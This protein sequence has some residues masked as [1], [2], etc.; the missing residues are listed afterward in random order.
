METRYPQAAIWRASPN[1]TP[2]NQGR[3]AAVVH[4]SEG[5]FD[6]GLGWLTN[7]AS[8]VSSHFLIAE[9]GRVAQM[10][11]L[12]DSSWANGLSFKA[13]AWRN[14][15]GKTVR[16]TWRRIAAPLNPNLQTVTIELAGFHNK[17]RPEAQ[18]RSLVSL[19]VWLGHQCGW[20]SYEVGENLI[21]HSHLDTADRKFC[22]GPHVDLAAIGALASAALMPPPPPALRPY[23]TRHFTPVLESPGAGELRVAWEGRCVLPPG[24]VVDLGDGPAG[25]LHWPAG[26]FVEAA[27]VSP[28]VA[29]PAIPAPTLAYGERSPLTGTPPISAER[30]AKV[31]AARGS[32][33]S[34]E[35]LEGMC[36]SYQRWGAVAGVD[37]F[38][39]LC[40]SAHETGANVDADPAYE[41]FSSWWAQPPRHNGSGYGVTGRV[42]RTP[43]PPLARVV[44]GVTYPLWAERGGGWYEGVSFPSWDLAVQAQFGRLLAYLH[45]ADATLSAEQHRLVALALAIRP[46]DI[47]ARGTVTELRHLG[48]HWNPANYQGG[49]LLPRKDWV[50]G[51]AW[52]GKAYAKG[53]AAYAN[54][55]LAEAGR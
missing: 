33:Y 17:P 9:D 44:D 24:Q 26:G 29:P 40:Q 55:V 8:G 50:A 6:S 35:A 41:P 15:R 18:L 2:G 51:W 36:E 27:L 37:W 45:P 31:L 22:P 34:P 43:P 3:L 20:R 4:I 54:G 47:R 16:P 5:S 1:I 38:L 32:A 11:D 10:V 30:C 19:L 21:G 12:A 46:L 48:A 42:E 28:V 23:S 7:A 13:G 49:E 14:H 25:W 39:A 52:D 53:I